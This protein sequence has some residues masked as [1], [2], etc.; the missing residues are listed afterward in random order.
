MTYEQKVNNHTNINNAH[1]NFSP[2]TNEHKNTT[3][4]GVVNPGSGLGTGTT[5]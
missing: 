3:T 4:Y 1:D 2:Q 5:M